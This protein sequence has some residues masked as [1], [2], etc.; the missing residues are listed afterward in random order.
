MTA[1]GTLLGGLPQETFRRGG[2]AVSRASDT[3]PEDRAAEDSNNY[4]VDGGSYACRSRRIDGRLCGEENLRESRHAHKNHAI[5]ASV[6]RPDPR[7]LAADR[8]GIAR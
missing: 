5:D 1:S 3:S 6:L 2:D 7:P 8:R 4:L